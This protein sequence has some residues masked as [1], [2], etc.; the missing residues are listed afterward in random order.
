MQLLHNQTYR[1]VSDFL[2]Y[3]ISHRKRLLPRSSTTTTG[4]TVL[5]NCQAGLAVAGTHTNIGEDLKLG[6]ELD[7]TGNRLLQ[8]QRRG[9]PVSSIVCSKWSLCHS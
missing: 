4:L 2:L 5:N 7:A 1:I 6:S 3:H 8:S 9:E